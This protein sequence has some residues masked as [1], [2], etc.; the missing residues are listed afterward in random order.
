[1]VF[2][3][4]VLQQVLYNGTV[5]TTAVHGEYCYFSTVTAECIRPADVIPEQKR[6][7][8]IFGWYPR[9]T[10]GSGVVPRAVRSASYRVRQRSD[11][12]R[13]RF[14]LSRTHTYSII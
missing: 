10:Q 4:A 9:W 8:N 1:M 2:V 7:R 12:P 14:T 3:T 6:Y 11:R 13:D 5:F